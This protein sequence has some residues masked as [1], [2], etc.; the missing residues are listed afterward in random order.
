V[1]RLKIVAMT[2][3][4]GV[5]WL[6]GSEIH[7][8]L[9]VGS[10]APDFALPGVDGRVHRLADYAASSVLVIVFTCNHC[11][12][13]QQYEQRIEQLY[14]DYRDKGVAVVAIQPNAPEAL[15]IDELDSSDTGDTLE[16]M[17]IRVTF[18]HLDYPYLY[19]GKTQAV[20]RAYGPQAT[21]HVF[22]FDRGRRLRYEGRFDSSY[23]EELVKTHDAR[24]AIDALLAGKP[25][26]VTHTG[27][28][29]CSTKWKEK[30]AEKREALRKLEEKPV[31][32]EPIMPAELKT[33]RANLAHKLTLVSVW[34]TE[35]D[36]CMAQFAGIEDTYRMYNPRGLEL[37]T[38]AVDPAPLEAVRSVL[39]NRHATSRNLL[40][41][42]GDSA[43][44]IRAVDPDGDA[45]LPYNVVIAPDGRVVYRNTGPVDMLQLRR[46]ILANID[47]EYAGFSRYWTHK[48]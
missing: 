21:P 32:L 17:K 28:F 41:S 16:E 1:R 9:K 34:S 31:T 19:D 15:R 40:F 2:L 47:W 35:C 29:G 48:E 4:V 5:S 39:E 37:V 11:P 26:F 30:E 23:R 38:I 8:I 33:L 43:S 14:H 25:V 10:S 42:S 12:I 3:L 24:N 6:R 13:S 18:K 36:P 45:S 22:V 44:L 7:P 20:A 27:V 46:A